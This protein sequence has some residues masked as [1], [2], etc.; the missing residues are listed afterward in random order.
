M[1]W[2]TYETLIF[3]HPYLNNI[4]KEVELLTP[5]GGGELWVKFPALFTHP[6]KSSQDNSAQLPSLS[7]QEIGL[8]YFCLAST[9]YFVS[10]GKLFILPSSH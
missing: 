1:S 5:E 9:N 4:V 2:R 3:I 7:L 8:Q 6:K 10:L